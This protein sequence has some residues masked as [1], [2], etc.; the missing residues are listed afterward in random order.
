MP[1]LPDPR[2]PD[3]VDRH[4]HFWVDVERLATFLMQTQED[5]RIAAYLEDYNQNPPKQYTPLDADLAV[6]QAKAMRDAVNMLL[7]I[8]E[9][10]T[11]AMRAGYHC[12]PGVRESLINPLF[13]FYDR[14][15]HALPDNPPP[16]SGNAVE[17]LVVEQSSFDASADPTPTE[18]PNDETRAANPSGS[19]R[20][21]T[22]PP[23]EPVPQSDQPKED[24]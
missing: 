9:G 15:R 20:G 7:A 14:H 3:K 11:Q 18:K 23:Q 8:K 12:Y 24:V 22:D 17:S 6:A 13:V 4:L 21:P 2:E 1:D 10:T 16:F 19:G 5:D